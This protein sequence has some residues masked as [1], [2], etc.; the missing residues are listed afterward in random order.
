MR[1]SGLAFGTLL[2][3][4]PLSAFMFSLF[5]AF[6]AVS[7]VVDDIQ[8]FLIVLLVPTR[9]E[10][11]M[12]YIRMFVENTQALGVVGLLFFLVT[13]VLLMATIQSTFNAA[14]GSRT[15]RNSVKKLATYASVLIV[16]GFLIGLGLNLT[17]AVT[18]VTVG[19]SPARS[20]LFRLLP[21]AVLFLAVFFMIEF[22]P[23]G[24]VRPSA[25]L[26]GALSGTV[27]WEI[28]R[29]LFVFWANYVIRLSVIYGSIAVIPIFLI[30][31]YLAWMIV[32]LSLEI[33]Y[34]LQYGMSRSPAKSGDANCPAERILLGLDLYFT[35]ARHFLDGRRP[36][37]R[38]DLSAQLNMPIS[39]VGVVAETLEKSD[40][41][42]PA[43]RTGQGLVP[44]RSLD[45]IPVQDVVG[46]LFGEAAAA[47]DTKRP[48]SKLLRTLRGTAGSAMGKRTVLDYLEPK[49]PADRPRAEPEN[50]DSGPED[51]L[52]GLPRLAAAALRKIR[53]RGSTSG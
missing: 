11:I 20:L 30:W 5:S 37:T 31:L 35:V 8:E 4:V 15:N 3:L 52:S 22:I 28:A 48:A 27:L 38:D 23:T 17:G 24:P 34:V 7:G 2:A 43:G 36:P 10:E 29:R 53:G 40:L 47:S 12:T 14:W 25:A 21:A 44:S 50:S 13:S 19:A 32:L 46:S 9:Q 39:D 42:L 1:A 33:T 41:L 18:S 49:E 45:K 51:P 26:V 16:G 6:G